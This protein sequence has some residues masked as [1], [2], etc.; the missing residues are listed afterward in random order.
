MVEK[1][2]G[3]SV[4]IFF[5]NF[6]IL[7][8]CFSGQAIALELSDSAQIQICN[9]ISDVGLDRIQREALQGNSAAQFDLGRAYYAGCGVEK[10]ARKAFEWFQ[11]AADQ[12]HLAG[13]SSV[14]FMYY[15]GWGVI[16]DR[17]KGCSTWYKAAELGSIDAI[18]AYNRNC[19]PD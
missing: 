2:P 7:V 17:K 16:R 9:S 3:V 15:N 4:K 6:L 11:K 18:D 5:K 10:N 1:L 8:F 12:A 19:N 13:M 14:G